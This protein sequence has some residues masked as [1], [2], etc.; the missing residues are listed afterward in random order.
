M[1][2]YIF[3]GKTKPTYCSS[4]SSCHQFVRKTI[5]SVSWS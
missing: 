4:S 5:A 2:C 3:S 1:N